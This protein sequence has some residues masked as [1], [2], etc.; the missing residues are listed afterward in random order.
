MDK[1]GKESGK[2]ITFFGGGGRGGNADRGM[3]EEGGGGRSLL[4]NCPPNKYRFVS[5]QT[6]SPSG[7]SNHRTI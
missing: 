6:Q 7:R 3:C 5:Q 2:T 4:G 1:R